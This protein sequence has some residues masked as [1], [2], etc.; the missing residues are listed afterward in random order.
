[1]VDPMVQSS[2]GTANN[3][4]TMGSSLTYTVVPSPHIMDL[5]YP[6]IRRRRNVDFFVLK[7]FM[8]KV[9]EVLFQTLLLTWFIYIYIFK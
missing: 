8:P 4:P 1:M 6:E 2:T 3:M 7:S 5:T 9:F